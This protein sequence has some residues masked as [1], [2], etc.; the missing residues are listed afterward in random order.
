MAV[1]LAR[2]GRRGERENL[3]FDQNV[4]VIGWVELPDLSPCKTREDIHKLLEETYPEERT[5]TLRSWLSQLNIF[6]FSIQPGDIIALPLKSRSAVAFG[7]VT[8]SYTYIADN[9]ADARHAR[10]VHWLKEIPRSGIDQD[11]L[12][13]LGSAMTVAGI[14]RNN[15]EAR[16]RAL[17]KGTAVKVEQKETSEETSDLEETIPD[18]E[19]LASDQIVEYI[20]KKFRG[21]QLARLVGAILEAQ[22]YRIQVS[23]PGAD[24]GVDIVAGKG[25]LGFDAP[26]I[27]VQVKSSD[28]PA[29]VKPIR[30]LQGVMDHVRADH[31]LFVSWGGYTSPVIRETSS[32]FFK[33]R[34]WDASDLVSMIQNH[35]SELPEEIQAELPL[36]RVWMLVGDE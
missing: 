33:I 27:V 23:P 14:K 29:D 20:S 32:Q 16:I 25:P 30:E 22:G 9:P 12:Y 18:L 26:R 24:G 17:L 15:S 1:W 35:Y 21:H 28:S 13:S 34:L 10:P 4:S 8:G 2:A 7:E 11:I 31:G 6:R 5:E 36:K 3:A 19:S